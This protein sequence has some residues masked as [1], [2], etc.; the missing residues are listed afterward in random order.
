MGGNTLKSNGTVKWFNATKGYGFITTDEG[1]DVFVHFSA[2]QGDET[3][4]HL[5]E[6]EAHWAMVAPVLVFFQGYDAAQPDWDLD[7]DPEAIS[8]LVH[9]LYRISAYWRTFHAALQAH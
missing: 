2:I 7:G 3:W 1:N 9:S 5:L 8:R 6:D 4:K